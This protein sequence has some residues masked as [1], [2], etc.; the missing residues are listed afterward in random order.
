MENNHS[1]GIEPVLPDDF[2]EIITVWEASVRATHH[3]LSEEDILFFKP[4]M[5]AQYLPSARL[6]CI[7]NKA[8]RIVAFLGVDSRHIDMLFVHPAAR[9]QGFGKAL[10]EYAF[11]SFSA[12]TVDVNEQN[13]QAVGFYKRMGFEVEG[14]DERDGMGKPFPILHMKKVP[15]GTF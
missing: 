13:E 7:R 8:G 10:L 9:R 1:F 5:S 4:L 6:F 3:F 15:V 14:R 12:D 11:S 2:E